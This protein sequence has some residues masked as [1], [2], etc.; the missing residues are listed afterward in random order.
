[1]GPAAPQ[2][3]GSVLAV[4]A[5]AHGFTMNIGSTMLVRFSRSSIKPCNTVRRPAFSSCSSSSA[6]IDFANAGV[7]VE[8]ARIDLENAGID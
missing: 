6:G 8:N 2:S 7:D 3:D 4:V 1:M 5:E